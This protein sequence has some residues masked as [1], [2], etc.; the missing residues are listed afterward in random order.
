[1]IVKNNASNYS[2]MSDNMTNDHLTLDDTNPVLKTGLVENIRISGLLPLY[3]VGIP[4]L[5]LL[6]LFF[7][8]FGATLRPMLIGFTITFFITVIY[9]VKEYGFLSLYSIFLYTSV[10]F[11]YTRVFIQSIFPESEFNFLEYTYPAKII[12]S[13]KEGFIFLTAAFLETY[14]MHVVYCLS[15]KKITYTQSNEMKQCSRYIKAGT[16]M[17]I[18]FFIPVLTKIII[19][20]RYI[21]AYGYS[22]VFLGYRDKIAYPI[23]VSGATAFFTAGYYVFLAGNPNKKQFLK[24]SIL[25][26]IVSALGALRGQRAGLIS[27]LI[28]SLYWYTKRNNVKIKARRVIGFGVVLM[29]L[30]VGLNLLRNSYG[31][32]ESIQKITFQQALTKI[33]EQSGS[34]VVPMFIIRG[35]LEYHDYPFVFS[36]LLTPVNSL[37]YR[38]TQSV[39][40]V[41]RTNDISDVITYNV[42]SSLY[43]NGG[44]IGSAFLGEAY[45]C[46]GFLGVIFWSA[47]LAF[48]IRFCDNKSINVKSRYVPILYAVLINIPLMPRG[49]LFGFTGSYLP[50]L[51]AYFIMFM[52]GLTVIKQKQLKT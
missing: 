5:Y 18:I 47:I 36:P 49:R 17:M 51:I 31:T 15:K 40:S 46:G 20:L 11:T 38:N 4:T 44:G 37:L 24:I 42:N 9:A 41:Q 14:I 7:S 28:I 1:M 30:I 3:I 27:F 34:S 22:S 35:N 25:Y 19:E 26:G 50:L 8:E 29:L 12:F 2:R 10:F 13:N 33:V 45:D 32:N 23:W 52:L 48:F 43:L 16:L 6:S 39:I 21:M